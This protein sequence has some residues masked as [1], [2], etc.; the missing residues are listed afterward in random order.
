VSCFEFLQKV[1]E[2]ELADILWKLGEERYS[3]KI[4]RKIV[5][6]RSNALLQNSTLDFASLI[7]SCFPP[8]ERYGRIH[9]A[10]RSFQALRI[11]LNS[12]L[13]ELESFL[14]NVII[15][16]KP[17]GRVAVLSFHSLEDR[18]VKQ[19]FIKNGFHKVTKKPIV[20]DEIELASNPRARS[21]KL[22]VA[23]KL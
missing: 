6:H 1:N 10:T 3:R 13:E 18:A 17:T 4:A 21:A 9:P 20:A 7:A 8:K 14:N 5:Q 22:R 23:E 2:S 15:E 16:L 19:A 11:Y 12:E